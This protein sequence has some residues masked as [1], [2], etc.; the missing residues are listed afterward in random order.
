M[1]VVHT[2]IVFLR[3][4]NVG[5]HTLVKMDVLK[6]AL[7]KNKFENV[8]TYIN[9]GN[10][11]IESG[12]DK[13]SVAVLIKNIINEIFGVSIGVIVKTKEELEFIIAKVPFD[14]EK[15]ADYAKRAVVLLSAFIEPEKITR[16]KQQ[17][18]MD[19]NYYILN[20]LI[21]IYYHNGAGRSKF[22]NAYVEKKLNVTST[23]RN[24]NTIL[25]LIEMVS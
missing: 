18:N 2:Y 1:S 16:F 19:E 17:N 11:V 20:D 21:Y 5:G 12:I 10:I 24:W 6:N 25:K 4:V 9:S 15:E 22:T 7:L 8:K 23:A 13:E 3:G 14:T